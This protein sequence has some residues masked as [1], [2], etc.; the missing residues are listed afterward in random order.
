MVGEGFD[1]P[2]HSRA[3]ELQREAGQLDVCTADFRSSQ[4]SF[5]DTTVINTRMIVRL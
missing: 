2:F 1:E 5:L 3:G 4:F